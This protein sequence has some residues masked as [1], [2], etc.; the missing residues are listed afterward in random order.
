MEEGLQTPIIAVGLMSGTSL[1]G[2]D[3]ALV[4]TDGVRVS[5]FGPWLT[6]RY[7][8]SL[9]IQ[10]AQA[11]G[12]CGTPDLSRALALAHKDAVDALLLDAGLNKSSIRVIGFH[13]HTLMHRPKDKLTVQSGDGDYLAELTGID[14]VSNFRTKDVAEGG[15]GAP[16]VPL[17]HA[18]LSKSLSAPIV[19]LNLGGIANLTW[20]GA[21]GDLLAFDSGPGNTLIDR[22]SMHHLNECMDRNGSLASLGSVNKERLARAMGEPYISTAPPKSLDINDLSLNFV[23]GLSPEDGAATLTAFTAATVAKAMFFLPSLPTRLLVSGGGRHNP[24]LMRMLAVELGFDVTP[25]ESVG[26][27]GDVVEA[28]AF[29]FLAVR[30]LLGLPLSLPKTTG[31]TSPCRGGQIHFA[32]SSL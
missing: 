15:Q 6:R 20:I 11:L 27:R 31:V 23:D 26:W 8:E 14:V 12:S 13:G 24:I 10:I 1:D 28:E 32:H 22:W 18:A 16:L 21:D 19:V 17:Y 29:A 30:T 3:V 25:V 2:I 4:R 9:R 7:Q 5:P